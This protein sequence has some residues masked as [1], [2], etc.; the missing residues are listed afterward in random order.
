MDY[1]VILTPDDNDTF[2]VSF[3]DVPDAITYGDTE[4]EALAHAAD[5]LATILEAY[6]KDRR[7]IPAPGRHRTPYRVA[8]PAL[9]A[10][11]VRLY[12][13]MRAAN[14]SKA[15]LARRL[16]WH[17][18]QVDR[19]IAMKHGSTLPQ[20]EAA[21]GAL[22]KR[23]VLSVEDAKVS[24]RRRVPRKAALAAPVRRPAKPSRPSAR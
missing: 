13:A 23:L 15:E 9:V 7:P 24:P 4:D 3:P 17:P 11:K 16:Q 1:P 5:A 6:V 8:V 22:G 2:L 14:V 18:P 20:L 12:E 19:L 21:F 10:T